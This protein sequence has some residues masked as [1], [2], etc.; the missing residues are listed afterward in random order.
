LILTSDQIQQ[1]PRIANPID[2]LTIQHGE[3][4]GQL[5]KRIFQYERRIL[6][7]AA[8]LL[9]VNLIVLCSIQGTKFQITAATVTLGIISNLLTLIVTLFAT[10]LRRK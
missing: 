6:V 1:D 8:A 5:V 10:N 3:L 7:F 9:L 2:E 4:F